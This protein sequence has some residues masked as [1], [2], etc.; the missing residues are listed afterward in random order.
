MRDRR[1]TKAR[2]RKERKPRQGC[3]V[4][5]ATAMVDHGCLINVS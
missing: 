3:I 1:K 4:D 2:R 5:L